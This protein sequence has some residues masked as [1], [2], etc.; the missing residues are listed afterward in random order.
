M[1]IILIYLY[2]L[3]GVYLFT[4][5]KSRKYK[6]IYIFILGFMSFKIITNYRTCSVA[7]AECKLRKV[8]R[9]ESYMNK[10]LDPL[11]DVRYS[12]HIYITFPIALL[13]FFHYFITEGHLRKLHQNIFN[14]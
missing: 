2:L 8:K 3:L 10:F 11:V 9:T 1:S 4:I 13:F 12:D 6:E 5:K 14:D 7:Y